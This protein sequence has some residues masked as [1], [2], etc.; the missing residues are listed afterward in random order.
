MKKLLDTGT[1]SH[2]DESLN[3]KIKLNNLIVIFSCV[4]CMAYIPLYLYFKLYSLVALTACFMA[5]SVFCFILQARKK[6]RMGFS[7]LT[8]GMIALM[9]TSSILFGLITNL[10]FF[11]LCI[12]MTTIIFFD[13]KK[14]LR[15]VIFGL[16][17]L[18]FFGLLLL[19][20]YK[21]ALTSGSEFLGY[22]LNI[23]GYFNY[24]VLFVFTTMFFTSFVRQNSV[25][26]KKILTHNSILEHKNTQI[27]DSLKYAKHLQDAILPSV[28]TIKEYLEE[29]FIVYRPKD[30]V[31]GDFYWMHA[32]NKN[33]IL[34]AVADSTGHGVPGAM[35]SVVCTNALNQ[36][37]KESGL[38]DPGKI[39]DKVRE[40]VA[41]FFQHPDNTSEVSDG[42]DISL[43]LI[44]TETRT[45]KWAGA[46]SPLWIIRE[47]CDA[48][49]IIK[50]DKQAVA[51]TDM[52]KPFTTHSLQLNAG[53]CFY[54]FTD[55]YADQFGGSSAKKYMQ[56]RIQKL[57]LS[58][59]KKTMSTQKK[60]ITDNLIHWMGKLEQVDDIC[61]IGIK[62]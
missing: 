2:N 22:V 55:G 40:L 9:S 21:T 13:D 8:F 61:F 32:K 7:V 44:D 50:P 38:T 19:L 34:F 28:S 16:S 62:L 17:L 52:P 18:C 35:V 14:I 33:E 11:M 54:L 53:D 15:H 41:Q 48:L 6:H 51:K 20:P 24:F 25:F 30:I 36:A 39:L 26:Q 47:N 49:T 59:Y 37:V 29:S 31:A 4:A 43:C 1:S 27:T 57:L 12:C 3:R 58:I 45:I 46:N 10:H 23:Y 60:L 56:K 5:L 42:M